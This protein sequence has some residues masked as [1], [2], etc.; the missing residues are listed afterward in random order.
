MARDICR[1]SKLLKKRERE[2]ERERKKK[3]KNP[4]N[5]NIHS[6]PSCVS[7]SVGTVAG[8]SHHVH[9]SPYVVVPDIKDSTEI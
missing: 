3:K 6:V 1:S 9:A 2:R 7:Y 8:P 5:W 4:R